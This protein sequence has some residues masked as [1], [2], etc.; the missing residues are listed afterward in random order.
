ML[1]LCHDFD[2]KQVVILGGGSVAL[3]KARRFSQEADVTVVSPEFEDGFEEVS[4]TLERQRVA[5]AD[6][7]PLVEDAYLVVPATDDQEL[8]ATAAEIA[9]DAGCLVN[10]VDE[11][12]DVVVPSHIQSGE[13]S[14]AISTSGASPATTRYLRKSL[15]P[16]IRE[17][18]GMVQI[19]RDLRARLK[20]TEPSQAERR[21]L[22]R[23]VVESDAVWESLPDEPDRAR[24]VADRIVAEA[25]DAPDQ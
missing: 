18:D 21:R 3:R 5:P 11:A 10:A 23:A 6:V 17:A 24:T 20:E 1:P 4:C 13:I 8:N 16:Q 22:L 25:R 15:T 14:L 12:G 9:T 19:Q 7:P 2:G